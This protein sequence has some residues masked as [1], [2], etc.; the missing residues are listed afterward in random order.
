MGALTT[1]FRQHVSSENSIDYKV[2]SS[3]R[4]FKVNQT[5]PLGFFAKSADDAVNVNARKR[6]RGLPRHVIGVAT[7]L[8]NQLA[9]FF[10]LKNFQNDPSFKFFA[11]SNYQESFDFVF[12]FL[13][14]IKSKLTWFLF[15][16]NL[17]PMH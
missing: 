15:C 6:S 11:L 9:K 8:I 3:V 1:S 14:R 10:K 13:G 2:F 12:F 4:F 5:D 16:P 17:L 7:D